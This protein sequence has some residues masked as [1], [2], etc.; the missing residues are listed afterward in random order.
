MSTFLFGVFC[1]V[2]GAMLMF[3][4]IG[5]FAY[6]KISEENNSKVHFYITPVNSWGYSELWFGNPKSEIKT[7]CFILAIGD[8]IKNYG[9]DP[10]LYTNIKEPVE[11]FIENE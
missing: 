2:I 7:K 5:L 10:S 4:S 9:V 8:D 3:F 11:V 6:G 1:F